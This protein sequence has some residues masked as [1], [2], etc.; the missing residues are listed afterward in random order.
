[1]RSKCM[2]LVFVATVLWL[3]WTCIAAS[4][5]LSTATVS[6]TLRHEASPVAGVMVHVFWEG[7]DRR[8]VT[9][10]DGRYTASGVPLGSWVMIH[11]LPPPQRRLAYRNW[12]TD[13]V[14]GDVIKDFDLVSGYL[15]SGEFRQ[16]DGSAYVQGFWLSANPVDVVPPVDEWIGTAAS[17]GQFELVVPPGVYC[18]KAPKYT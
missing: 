8:S 10:P 16:P 11:V 5:G 6:G 17:H 15:L 1:M 2:A 13:D 12:R 3:C 9:G 18:L 4:G 14:T 7:G